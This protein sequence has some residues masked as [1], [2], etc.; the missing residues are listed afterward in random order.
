MQA[1]GALEPPSGFPH[2][3]EWLIEW[4]GEDRRNCWIDVSIAPDYIA[5]RFN[6][7]SPASRLSSAVGYMK[8]P[9]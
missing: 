1:E 2:A 6:Q 3:A 9:R 4:V 7:Q 5:L 8:D